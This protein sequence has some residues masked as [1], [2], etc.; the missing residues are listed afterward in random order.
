MH[1]KS[2]LEKMKSCGGGYYFG[3][4]VVETCN[5]LSLDQNE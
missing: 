3:G 2:E 1:R 5:I 4:C